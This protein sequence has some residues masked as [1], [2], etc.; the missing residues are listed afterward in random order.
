MDIHQL[1][2]MLL[3]EHGYTT[4]PLGSG[5]GA[6]HVLAFKAC[7]E[8]ISYRSH[9]IRIGFRDATRIIVQS[10]FYSMT[11]GGDQSAEFSV[12]FAIPDHDLEFT[13]I[14]Q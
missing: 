14:L 6:F 8:S 9:V 2:Y 5:N 3:N 7:P 4:E 13:S 1:V 12:D 11:E 10:R